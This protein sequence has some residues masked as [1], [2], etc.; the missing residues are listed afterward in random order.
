[1]KLAGRRVR[2]EP[3][4]HRVEVEFDAAHLAEAATLIPGVERIDVRRVQYASESAYA[5]IRCFKAV[6]VV[7]SAAVE[8]QYG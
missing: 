8:E 5:M 3:R 2:P 7:V 1:M 4:G 6:T